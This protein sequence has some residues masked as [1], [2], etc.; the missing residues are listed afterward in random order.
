MHERTVVAFVLAFPHP[1]VAVTL[2][3]AASELALDCGSP[4]LTAVPDSAMI[5]ATMGSDVQA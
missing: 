5:P 3:H 4:Q 2:N 1:S